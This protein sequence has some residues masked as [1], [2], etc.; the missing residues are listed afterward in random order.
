M[1][2]LKPLGL[3]NQGRGFAVVADEVRVLSKR[4]QDSTL[5]IHSTIDTLQ[6]T[7]AKAVELMQCSQRL[8]DNSV[9]D[10]DSAA[11]A[12]EEITQAVN[13]ISDMAGQ[14]ATAAEEQS[15]V[16]GEITLN[17]TA[18]KD[19]TDDITV[20]AL[21]DLEQ[22]KALKSRAQELKAEVATFIL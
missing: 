3:E 11:Q 21:R 20:S 15:Q 14:I 16:T 1:P 12:L 19:V 4:T 9:S 6:Q 2:L 17:T 22:A 7:T 13:L 5:E 10:A 18:I 8:A